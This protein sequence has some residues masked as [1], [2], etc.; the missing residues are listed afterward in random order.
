[1]PKGLPFHGDR[2]RLLRLLTLLGG[3]VAAGPLRRGRSE[4]KAIGVC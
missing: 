4:W 3:A 2:E 1:M